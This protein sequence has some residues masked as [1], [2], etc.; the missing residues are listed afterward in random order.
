MYNVT[1][2]FFFSSSFMG[3]GRTLLFCHEATK[4]LKLSEILTESKS[5]SVP[6]M[7]GERL[8]IENGKDVSACRLCMSS[9]I[10]MLDLH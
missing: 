2:V 5:L 9:L 6:K 1:A 3:V 10:S 7:H 4:T 8:N